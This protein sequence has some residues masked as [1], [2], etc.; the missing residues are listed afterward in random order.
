M[1]SAAR[2]AERLFIRLHRLIQDGRG[3]DGDADAIRDEL[4]VALPALT[5][6]ER[7]QLQLLSGDL[8]LV[9]RQNVVPHERR[10]LDPVSELKNAQAA[11]LEGRWADMLQHLR[12]DL[13]SIPRDRAAY[14]RGRGWHELGWD[15]GA[16]AF[17]EY[18]YKLE[19]NPNYLAL[20][21][22]SMQAL[23]EERRVQETVERI[24][25]DSAAHPTLLYKAALVVFN[26]RNSDQSENSLRRVERRVI[27]LVE[28][29]RATKA[30]RPPV[31]SLTAGAFI[32]CGFSYEHRGDEGRSMQ[33]FDEAI[34]VE[35]T[36]G[37]ETDPPYVARAFAWLQR[38]PARARSDFKRAV[39]L[40]TSLVWPYFYLAHAALVQGEFSR[41]TSLASAGSSRA[42][43]DQG[44]LKAKL[45]EW[46]AIASAELGKPSTE[47]LALFDVA[48]SENPTDQTV[49]RNRRTYEVAVTEARKLRTEEWERSRGFTDAQLRR[50]YLADLRISGMRSQSNRA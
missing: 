26:G 37:K 33:W 46:W 23:G 4:D 5:A 35:A 16:L 14:F 47:V 28:R 11:M 42:A 25:R 3:D 39:E 17:F 32:A 38:D 44:E 6:E 49:A 43:I 1:T 50:A 18:A 13:R 12:T 27:A 7:R 40:K 31:P 45:Y 2:A 41:A 15:E 21:I 9:T 24:E 36:A 34:A 20:A 19:K 8:F 22:D 30:D 48:R 10:E 29:G